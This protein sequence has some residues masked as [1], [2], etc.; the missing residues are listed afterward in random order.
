MR[1]MIL[2][3][4]SFLFLSRA[5]QKRRGEE[6]APDGLPALRRHGPSHH[7][8]RERPAPPRLERQ[9]S[10]IADHQ[11]NIRGAGASHAKR[12]QGRLRELGAALDP[13]PS[14]R[15]SELTLQSRQP[16]LKA[17]VKRRKSKRSSTPTSPQPCERSA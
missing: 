6:P 8:R 4:V 10:I 11:A 3:A 14:Q 7:R 1:R 2:T 17:L 13:M 5:L 15:G 16:A 12:K 9:I